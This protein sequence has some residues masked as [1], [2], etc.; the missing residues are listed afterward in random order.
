MAKVEAAWIWYRW[1]ATPFGRREADG[2]RIVDNMHS[3]LDTLFP[4]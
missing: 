2:Y 1:E 4:G 3:R